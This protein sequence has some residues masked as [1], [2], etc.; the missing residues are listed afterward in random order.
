MKR[1]YRVLPAP[2]SM[3]GLLTLQVKAQSF[4]A[5]AGEPGKGVCRCVQSK[6]IVISDL[7]NQRLAASASASLGP[8][9]EVVVNKLQHRASDIGRI[10][11]SKLGASCSPVKCGSGTYGKNGIWGERTAQA[12]NDFSPQRMASD[13]VLRKGFYFSLENTAG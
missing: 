5:L 3:S 2:A 11:N 12:R 8:A 1:N 4:C 9:S 6:E 7:L 13:S 10:H